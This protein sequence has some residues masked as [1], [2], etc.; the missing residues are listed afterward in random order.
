MFIRSSTSKSLHS[1]VHE[2]HVFIDNE[3]AKS[4]PEYKAATAALMAANAK[5][6]EAKTKLDKIAATIREFASAIDRVVTLAAKV[7]A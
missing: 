6:V 3:V 4:L 2:L 5:A 7:A 1:R